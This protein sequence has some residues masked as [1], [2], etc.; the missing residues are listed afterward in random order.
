MT[1][2]I[3]R[4]TNIHCVALEK[5]RCI[6]DVECLLRK[7]QSTVLLKCRKLMPITE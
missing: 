5:K 3:L 4:K 2:K 7:L 6:N 1:N